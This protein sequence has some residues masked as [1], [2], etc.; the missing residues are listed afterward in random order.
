MPLGGAT[1]DES[2]VP[3]WTR[4]DF[5]G[6]W[7]GTNPPGSTRP[8]LCL[9][10]PPLR[11]RGFSEESRALIPSQRGR[12]ECVLRLT[13]VRS[14]SVRVNDLAAHPAARV[15]VTGVEVRNGR[16]YGR[17]PWELSTV[18]RAPLSRVMEQSPSAECSEIPPSSAARDERAMQAGLPRGGSCCRRRA[19]Q[20]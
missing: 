10:A 5:R 18:V 6:F 12:M 16:A 3:P 19:R 13:P 17:Q 2:S 4:G 20:R 1:F 7:K 8:C 11:R 15:Y 9:C 14:R